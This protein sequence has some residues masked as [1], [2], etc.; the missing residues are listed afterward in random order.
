MSVSCQGGDLT[1]KI[2][3][4]LAQQEE[5][6][7][8][9]PVLSQ[10]KVPGARWCSL[11]ELHNSL[12]DTSHCCVSTGLHNC[13]MCATCFVW[14]PTALMR[15]IGVMP[16]T[17]N[18][19]DVPEREGYE[20]TYVHAEGHCTFVR[21]LVSCDVK[22]GPEWEQVDVSHIYFQLANFGMRMNDCVVQVQRA[23]LHG[24]RATPLQPH[25][26]LTM[27]CL[28]P[29]LLGH[30]LDAQTEALAWLPKQAG[31]RVLPFAWPMLAL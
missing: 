11:P 18:S 10:L 13:H 31:M 27:L 14:I 19:S 25:H 30:A 7:H 3:F 12:A 29:A 17:Y 8:L 16:S 2:S 15:E 1:A 28:H 26:A 4:Q 21:L 5:V 9:P 20:H 24:K 23:H 6:L 22:R